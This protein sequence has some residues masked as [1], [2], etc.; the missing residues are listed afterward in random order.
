MTYLGLFLL[1]IDTALPLAILAGMLE[2]IPT[3][4][5]IVSSIPAVVIA[6]VVHPLLG[7]STAALYFLIQFIENNLLVP[8][9]MQKTTG[10]SPLVSIL[11][12]MVGF[13]LGGVVGAVL[14]IPLI[15][16]FQTLGPSF[17]S[18]SRLEDL[19]EKA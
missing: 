7:L 5:P 19:S 14:A 16:V 12:L 18:L 1:G 15:L 10:V 8:Q 2:I 4:G 9:V 3:V 13:R 11:G 17:F 6:S